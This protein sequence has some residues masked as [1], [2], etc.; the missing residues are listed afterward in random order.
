MHYSVSFNKTLQ[1]YSNYTTTKHNIHILQTL[2]TR[3][4]VRLE[5]LIEK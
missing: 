3:L 2:D 5:K 4:H 1:F